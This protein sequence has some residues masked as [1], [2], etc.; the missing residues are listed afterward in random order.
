MNSKVMVV[1]LELNVDSSDTIFVDQGWL[2]VILVRIRL[3]ELVVLHRHDDKLLEQ[4]FR[5]VI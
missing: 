4:S 5:Q 1:W 3:V 2:S